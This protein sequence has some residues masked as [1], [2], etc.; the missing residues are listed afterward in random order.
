MGTADK[1][2]W[3]YRSW[4]KITPHIDGKASNS[5][6]Y[7]PAITFLEQKTALNYRFGTLYSNKM[8]KRY[9][10]K[11]NSTCTLCPREDGVG[12]IAGGCTHPTMERMYTE[13]HN[14]IGRILLRAIAKGHFGAHII[15]TDLGSQDK[16]TVQGAPH[17]PFHQ[18]PVELKSILLS[19][20]LPGETRSKPDA[21]ILLPPDCNAPDKRPTLI[22]LEFKTCR[23][24]DPNHQLLRSKEQHQR[25]IARL[26]ASY[27]VSFVPVLI[28]HS[29][30]I[31]TKHT[32]HSMEQLGID[33]VAAKKYASKMHIAAV[34]QLHSIVMTK[35]HLEHGG[36]Q[37]EQIGIP[38]GGPDTQRTTART[39][40]PQETRQPKRPKRNSDIRTY[41][42]P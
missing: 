29:G 3:Y 20:P 24:T 37:Q 9:C 32:L 6:L 1:N 28:G 23:C 11:S 19:P 31:Y 39:T 7:N 15:A 34:K 13:R 4:D 42:P 40:A 38:P 8:A 14:H 18:I 17:M 22:L 30:T 12:H 27:K 25:L 41:D 21:I 36:T 35:R 16:S 10:L 2:S 5:Y 33:A 26:S